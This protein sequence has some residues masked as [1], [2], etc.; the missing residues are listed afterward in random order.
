MKLIEAKILFATQITNVKKFK[1][2]HQSCS[3]ILNFYFYMPWSRLYLTKHGTFILESGSHLFIRKSWISAFTRAK[4][5]GN[6]HT[7]L[8]F[9]SCQKQ[10]SLHKNRYN[11]GYHIHWYM[12]GAIYNKKTLHCIIQGIN[13][14]H[15][16]L[17]W[18]MQLQN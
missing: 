14:M 13:I 6:L 18:K 12:T 17:R 1:C 4:F 8:N 11:P 16:I 7:G 2:A 15:F 5:N 10:N 3:K 9:T